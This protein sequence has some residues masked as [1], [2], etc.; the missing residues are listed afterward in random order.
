[1]FI[2]ILI[3]LLNPS[4]T[5]YDRLYMTDDVKPIEIVCEDQEYLFPEIM[6]DEEED[7]AESILLGHRR[8]DYNGHTADD[9]YWLYQCVEA[10]EGVNNHRAKYLAACC[11]LNRVMLGWGGSTI[12]DVIFAKN[13]FQVVTNGRINRVYPSEDTIRACNEALDNCEEWVIAFAQGNLH[14]LWAKLVEVQDGEYFY[15]SK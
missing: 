4:I 9:I 12:T 2:A 3:T 13:Q 10:E 11:I 7:F 14:K 15:E 1:M 5:E 8:G 6:T